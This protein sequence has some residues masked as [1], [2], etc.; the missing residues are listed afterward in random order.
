[1]YCALLHEA[2]DLVLHHYG[3][4]NIVVQLNLD[5]VLQL[6]ILPQEVFVVNWVRKVLVV[7]SQQIDLAV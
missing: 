5:F 6:A 4:V 1:M 2:N 3:V 7:L